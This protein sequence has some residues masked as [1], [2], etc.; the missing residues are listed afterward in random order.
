MSFPNNKKHFYKTEV[1][2]LRLADQIRPPK[3]NHP[4]RDMLVR[5]YKNMPGRPVCNTIFNVTISHNLRGS[6][7]MMHL[8]TAGVQNRFLFK[9]KI[10]CRIKNVFILN[11]YDVALLTSKKSSEH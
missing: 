1:G 7:T 6:K 8:V 5:Y 4:T 11:S 3:Q 9:Y 2:N 10:W